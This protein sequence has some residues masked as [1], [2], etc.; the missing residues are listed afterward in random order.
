MISGVVQKRSN[1]ALDPVRSSKLGFQGAIER[2]LLTLAIV[3]TASMMTIVPA[4]VAQSSVTQGLGRSS[5][6]A[7]TQHS[8]CGA[9]AQGLTCNASNRELEDAVLVQAPQASAALLPQL[10]SNAQME[11]IADVLLELLYFVLPVGFGI[12]LFL[13]DRH[14]AQRTAILEAH[15]KLLEKLWKQ[16][17]QV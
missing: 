2:R 1:V 7:T 13:H 11:S 15:I 4:A 14:Q 8:T 6:A 16:T 12:G 10:L 17:P 3:A 5:I 9:D